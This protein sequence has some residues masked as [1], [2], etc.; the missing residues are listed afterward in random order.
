MKRKVGAVQ[1]KA[2]VRAALCGSDQVRFRTHATFQTVPLEL[3]SLNREAELGSAAAAGMD[4]PQIHRQPTRYG[5]DG[6]FAHRAQ[7]ARTFG[8]DGQALFDWRILRLE[9]HHAPGTLHERCSDPR[10]S[11]LGHTAWDSFSSTAVFSGA[12]PGVRTD[13]P[14][15]IEPVPVTD[16]AREYHRGQFAQPARNIERRGGFQFSSEGI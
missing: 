12:Q 14:P 4:A 1:S 15:V 9:A 16:L 11:S 5:D 13:C 7:S 2:T 3:N 8:E 6:F 10:I